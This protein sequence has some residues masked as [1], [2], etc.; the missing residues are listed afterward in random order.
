MNDKVNV[1]DGVGIQLPLLPPRGLFKPVLRHTTLR[2]RFEEFHKLNPHVLDYLTELALNMQAKGFYHYGIQGLFNIFRWDPRVS[3]TG[4]DYKITNT[5]S[6]YYAR[7]IME[8][9]PRLQGFFITKPL[10]GEE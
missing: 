10:K 6:P 7:L 1:K 9:E 5:F 4:G 8:T 3:T 2:E